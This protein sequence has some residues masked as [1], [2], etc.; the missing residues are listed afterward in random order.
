[1]LVESVF[2]PFAFP[3]FNCVHDLVDCAWC[4]LGREIFLYRFFDSGTNRDQIK[5][6]NVWETRLL[7]EWEWEVVESSLCTS[8]HGEKKV[9]PIIFQ[10]L[11][12]LPTPIHFS[13]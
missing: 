12:E 9:I 5:V 8:F 3:K 10:N 11:P 4:V 2:D 1:M 13:P 7:W 6:R